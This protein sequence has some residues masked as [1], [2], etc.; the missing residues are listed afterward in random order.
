[1]ASVNCNAND[2]TAQ[3]DDDFLQAN[4]AGFKVNTSDAEVNA[5]GG[6]Y[7]FLAVANDPT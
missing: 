6:N 1:M 7:I 4:N 3:A 5:S 2:F